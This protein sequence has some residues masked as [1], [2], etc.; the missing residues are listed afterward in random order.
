MMTSAPLAPTWPPVRVAPP[1]PRNCNAPLVSVSTLV[2]APMSVICPLLPVALIERELTERA[3]NA[4]AFV[5][6]RLP[7][8][9]KVVK[10]V[11]A[12]LLELVRP[13]AVVLS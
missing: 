3:V 7:L 6:V 2:L 13:V 9:L 1:V 10:S 4:P 5:Q 11:V 8:L 12:E